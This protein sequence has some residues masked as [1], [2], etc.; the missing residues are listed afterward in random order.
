MADTGGIGDSSIYTFSL[1]EKKWATIEEVKGLA[2]TQRQMFAMLA[3]GRGFLVVGGIT[4][5]FGTGGTSPGMYIH[6]TCICA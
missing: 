3:T 5:S 6:I 4:G 1:T 2:P